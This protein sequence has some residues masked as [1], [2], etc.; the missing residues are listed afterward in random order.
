MK[1]RKLI[2]R[3][4]LGAF[5]FMAMHDFIVDYIDSDTQT[6]LYMKN[7]DNNTILC[8]TSQLHELIHQTL[9]EFIYS[10]NLSINPLSKHISLY[11]DRNDIYSFLLG[12]K[13]YR[14]PIA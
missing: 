7:I 4:L 6:E 8:E 12:H 11:Q 5:V 13:L 3:F 2:L 14:P 9:L 10:S 1:A